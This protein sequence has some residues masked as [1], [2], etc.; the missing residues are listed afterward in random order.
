MKGLKKIIGV[1]TSIIAMGVVTTAMAVPPPPFGWYIEG[2]IGSS[3]VS[4]VTYAPNDSISNSGRAYNINGGYKF[5]PYFAGEIGYTKYA[6]AKAKVGSVS[7]ATDSHYSYDI[8]AKGIL[9]VAQSG[10]EFFAKL[11]AA[12]LKSKVTQQNASFPLNNA[13]SNSTTG[14]YYGLG[15][16]YTVWQALALVGQ[17]QRAKGNNKTGNY[18]LYSLG[19]SYTFA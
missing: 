13:G 4:N 6:D 9:P 18:D 5:L 14:Y 10:L 15:A 8:A 19:L 2:N 3:K 1:S 16:D 12:R 11:G 7:V 17:W